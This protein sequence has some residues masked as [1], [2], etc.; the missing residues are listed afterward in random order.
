MSAMSMADDLRAQDLAAA[1]LFKPSQGGWIVQAFPAGSGG[2]RPAV[3]TPLSRPGP[4]G[5][6]PAGLVVS[7]GK[8]HNDDWR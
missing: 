2:A 7:G 5:K 8:V 1:A 6:R 3:L 4:R